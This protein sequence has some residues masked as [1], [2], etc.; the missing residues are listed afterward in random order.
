MPD[1]IAIDISE[2]MLDRVFSGRWPMKRLLALNTFDYV[3]HYDDFVGNGLIQTNAYSTVL[4]GAA[5]VTLTIRADQ[6]NGVAR[7]DA[8]SADDGRSAF[9]ME[10]N[11][12]GDNSCVMAVRLNVDTATDVK[13]E[14]GFTDA[15]ADTSAV[16]TLSTPSFTATDCAL[17]ILDTDDTA[18]WQGVATP[19][20]DSTPITKHEPGVAPVGGTFETLIVALQQ[21]QSASNV[22]AARFMRLNDTGEKVEDSDSGWLPSALNSNVLLT[23]WVFVQNRS[24]NQRFCDIDFIRVWQRRS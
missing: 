19:D 7:M 5:A 11:Y 3:M 4:S 10:L 14:V 22:A 6:R 20:G 9:A 23:P 18:N 2:S 8:G 1:P 21:D 15:V 24:A 13:C 12:R 17:W 16:A